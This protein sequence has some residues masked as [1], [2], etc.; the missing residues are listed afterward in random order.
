MRLFYFIIIVSLVSCS[1][2]TVSLPKPTANTQTWVPIYVSPETARKVTYTTPRPIVNSGKIYTIGNY[3]LQVEK[4]SGIH[5]INYSNRTS[6]QKTGFIR[7]LYCSEMS[8]KGQYLYLNNLD[9]L[10]VLNIA[11]ITNPVEVNRVP[12]AF[13]VN[14]NDYPPA[15]NTFFECPDHSKGDIVGWRLEIRDYPKCY[16]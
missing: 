14:L 8:V 4:D 9:D 7:S 2:G 16:R 12:H 5:I 15:R 13:P 11:D 10:V 3:L 6:P 1:P